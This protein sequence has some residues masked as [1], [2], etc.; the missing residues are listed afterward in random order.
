M[1]S[2]TSIAMV[3]MR[4]MLLCTLVCV[5]LSGVRAQNSDGPEHR[6]PVE[7]TDAARELHARAILFD[8]HNDLPWQ[9][10]TRGSI[11]FDRLDLSQPNESMHTDIPRLRRG[12]VG[13]QFWSVYV[14][15]STAYDGTA[16][17]ATL[18][19]I[20]LV[21]AMVER[22]PNTFELARTADDVVRIHSSGRIASL[23]GVEGGHSIENSLN[24]LNQLY[25]LGARYM[26][27]THSDNLDW[28][29]SA[30]DERSLGGL[31]PFGED[32]IRE[33]NRLGML[34]DLSHVSPETMK[35]TLRINEA[36]VIFSHS[37]ARAVAD[38]PRNVPDDVL[39]LTKQNGGVVMVNFYSGY[40]VPS[41]A[42]FSNLQMIERKKLE[43]ELG[44][45]KA[46]A[47]LQKWAAGRKI[48]AGTIHDLVDHIDHIVQVAGI[49]H[50]GLGSDYDGVG[51]LPAQLEDV[52]T[53]PH[54]TQAMLD[55][56]YSEEDILKTL[57]GNVL[58]VMRE[59][60]QV[61]ERL[62][63]K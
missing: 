26:T 8:G 15:A 7:L 5:S 14:P 18:E 38:H 9:I 17:T 42:E 2:Y 55:R 34:V 62:K 22:Y 1:P 28:A 6:P 13:A 60:E 25:R 16:L 43:K 21:H 51:L 52:S 29:D 46:V 32:V 39:K 27:L 61:A 35:H 50:V 19:Q 54:I 3:P 36:P 24:V 10:R 58:R 44:K 59:A 4:R 23:I 49:D 47:A 41:S 30:T 56:G 37:S 45:E 31:S 33:M 57:G 12:G 53:Y 40:V 48:S 20:E 11:S 63:R